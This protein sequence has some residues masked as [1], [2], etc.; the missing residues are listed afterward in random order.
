MQ[1]LVLVP[2]ITSG[3]VR[4]V[5]IL[6]E[7]VV[8]RLKNRPRRLFNQALMSIGVLAALLSA[9]PAKA[10]SFNTLFGYT[11]SI[12][13]NIEA[14]PQ[15]LAVMENPRS[16]RTFDSD[17]WQ[18]FQA[19]TSELP[20]ATQLDA[21]NNFVNQNDYVGD[22]ENY[23]REDHWATPEQLQKNGGDCED[24]AISKLFALLQLGWA[25]ESLRLVVV[26]D[27]QLNIPHAILAVAAEQK[28]WILDNQA[29]SVRS[30][31]LIDHYAPIYSI[32][33]RQWWLHKPQGMQMAV[34]APNS[35]QA[36][37]AK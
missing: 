22:P 7:R 17:S 8:C 25:P 2:L 3:G 4:E 20:L 9:V 5:W 30:A 11:E 12:Q 33:G 29:T 23:G 28:I 27:T 21:V 6:Y 10:D 37:A 13:S 16:E 36:P 18:Q 14:F 26:Q 24:F 35:T 19:I 15:W 1:S 31:Q 34:V 32:S